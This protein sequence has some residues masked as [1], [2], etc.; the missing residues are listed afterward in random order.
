MKKY[1]FT[2]ITVLFLIFGMTSNAYGFG[3]IN[4]GNARQNAG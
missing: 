3:L 2:F 1:I 4:K